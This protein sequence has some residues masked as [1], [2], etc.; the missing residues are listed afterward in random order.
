M[1]WTTKIGT[2]LAGCRI[3]GVLGRGGM[4]VVYVAVDRL[5]RKVA[6]KVLAP[7]LSADVQFQQRFR[8]E[9]RILASLDHPNIVP[10]YDAGECDGMLYISMRYIEG[11]DLA[12]LIAQEGQL[13]VSRTL[14]IVEQIAR[15]LD[16]AHQAALVHRDVKPQNILLDSRNEQAYLSDFG[17]VK[18]TLAASAVLT[19]VGDF[20]GTPDYCA[21]EQIE[22][23]PLDGRTDLYAFGGVAFTCLTG[24]APYEREA[25]VAAMN[26][27][28]TEPPPVPSRHRAGLPR[29]LDAVIAKAMA[30]DPEQRYASCP[31]FADAFREAVLGQPAVAAPPLRAPELAETRLSEAP[32][33]RPALAE[34]RPGGGPAVARN[35]VRPARPDG[36]GVRRITGLLLA[37]GVP[38]G[39]VRDL[40][41]DAEGA[42]TVGDLTEALARHIGWFAPAGA[43]MHLAVCDRLGERLG[44]DVPISRSGLRTGDRVSLGVDDLDA[45]PSPPPVTV[46]HGAA[47]MVV[48]AGPA[49]GLGFTLEEGVHTLGRDSSND[50]SLDDPSL[51]RRHL[52]L[53]VAAGKVQIEDAGSSN[54]TF[55]EDVA[56]RPGTLAA[57]AVGAAIVAGRSVL[58][59]EGGA[60]TD[61][62]PG[63]PPH[64][65]VQL[66]APPDF[67]H[68]RMRR[69]DHE[70]ELAE[71]REQTRQA[72]A[73]LT[74][75]R[76]R[77][78]HDRRAA[79]P[80]APELL[81]RARTHSQLWERRAGDERFLALRV[82]V[83]DL[84]VEA[85]LDLAAG[86]DEVL[87]REV[88]AQ[89]AELLLA[90]ALPA[91]VRLA[92]VG[93]LG[94]AGPEGAATSLVRWLVLQ[95]AVL[96]AP[97]ELTVAAGVPSEGSDSWSFLPWLPHTRTASPLDGPNLA[98]GEIKTNRLIESAMRLLAARRRET[99]PH[100][101]ALLVVLDDRVVL[102][103]ALAQELLADGPARGM[104]TIW[105]AHGRRDLPRECGATVVLDQALAQ[106]SLRVGSE[107]ALDRVSADGLSAALAREAA[108]GLARAVDDSASGGLPHRVS[109][110]DLL[111]P[112]GTDARSVAA[113]W[114]AGP[115]LAPVGMAAEGAIR[116]ALDHAEGVSVLVVGE[117]GSG[118]SELLRTL[119][120]SLALAH[121]PDRLA[122][123]IVDHRGQ[124]GFAQLA[125]LP[126]DVRL[127]TDEAATNAALAGLADEITRRAP[128]AG[129]GSL[130]PALVIVVDDLSTA[131]DSAPSFVDAVRRVAREGRSLGIHLVLATRRLTGAV[132]DAALADA[133]LR[134]ALRVG[135]ASASQAIVGTSLAASIP[136]DLPGRGFVVTIGSPAPVEFHVARSE[137]PR[138]PGGLSALVSVRDLT[139]AD[140]HAGATPGAD[141]EVPDSDL[142][143]LVAEITV[144]AEKGGS[145]RSPRV[146]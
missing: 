131:V 68:G 127:V 65:I 88:E 144:A 80:D 137:H 34:T 25:E 78:I 138:T 95:A 115:P 37:L 116:I 7:A 98:V 31:A 66:A 36:A 54:G 145:D 6:L 59:L 77:E 119:V 124:G 81:E 123:L 122:F 143:Q 125:G 3:Q 132:G 140:T 29:G 97:A 82:G 91:T 73:E 134:V 26:A 93:S 49:A 118:K 51:S 129:S 110:P 11:P 146:D 79:A 126:H 12:T 40:R 18:H 23:L 74:A 16:A 52:R 121:P 35:P 53:H 32:L 30:K 2:E 8:R 99:A 75:A 47:R 10:I 28:L 141:A 15:A 100:R 61:G 108:R 135:T 48:S 60:T 22:G 71:F 103:G 89:A 69:R 43:Q 136:A 101:P 5:G 85:R 55:L 104:F 94:I 83:A 120:V 58:R 117:P 92:A 27:H 63:A 76:A 84:S 64:A 1:T 67:A 111:E 109:L 57:V 38:D 142:Q 20:L 112:P 113:R 128:L 50:V 13:S 9:W 114:R 90:P 41:V 19:R 72:L 21:P 14:L 96:S 139:V 45:A 87:R 86:G 39:R 46:P 130:P 56:V 4:S 133:N 24:C 105:L 17:I 70:R 102:D 62:A 42:A 44:R 33:E 106:L 107:E